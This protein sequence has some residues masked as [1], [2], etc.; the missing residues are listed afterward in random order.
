MTRV[1]GIV[2]EGNT[3]LYD[4]VS[5]AYDELEAKAEL[6]HIRSIVVLSD[7]KD[8]H[9]EVSV[10]Q[11][12][13][14]INSFADEGGS[15]IKLFTIGFGDD[16]DKGILQSISDPTGGRQYDAS[17]ENINEIYEEIATFF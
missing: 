16:A 15:S 6:E 2:E 9:S 5:F 11:L 7:G 14:E 17:P 1:S 10:E 4:A 12:I 8:T 3:R 13:A